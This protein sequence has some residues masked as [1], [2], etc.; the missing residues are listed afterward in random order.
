MR[1]PAKG[2]YVTG[3]ESS[4]NYL[5]TQINISLLFQAVA[6][7][8]L[9][10]AQIAYLIEV[11]NDVTGIPTKSVH[12]IGHSLGAHVAGYVGKRLTRKNF[13]LGRISGTF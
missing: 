13:T 10:G 7:T 11:L 1:Q 6:N 5:S 3:L 12:I 4:F 8:R 2:G 9:V